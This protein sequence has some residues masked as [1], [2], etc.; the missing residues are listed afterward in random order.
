MRLFIASAFPEEILRVINERL[1]SVKPNL[2]AASWVR[3]ETQ[4]LTFTFLGEQEESRIESLATHVRAALAPMARFDAML[5]GCGFFP[6]ARRA[7]VGWVG[8]EPEERFCDIARALRDAVQSF[9]IELDRA[10]FKAHLTLMRIRD[11][12]PPPAIE[13]FENALRDFRSAPFAVDRVTLYSSR[14]SPKGAIHTALREF[15]LS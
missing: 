4:H 11:R 12:W 15:P 5:R 14:L 8:A 7:R 1:A 2:P 13:K 10:D 6:N 3:P 9:G